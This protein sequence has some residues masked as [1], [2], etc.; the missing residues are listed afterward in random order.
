MFATAIRD[1]ATSL[2]YLANY[3]YDSA[4]YQARFK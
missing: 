1:G 4:E 3:L 2:T